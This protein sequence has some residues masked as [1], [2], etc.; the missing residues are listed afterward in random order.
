MSNNPTEQALTK[1]YQGRTF[2]VVDKDVTGLDKGNVYTTKAC[3]GRGIDSDG[4]KAPAFS[5]EEDCIIILLPWLEDN[6]VMTEL[7]V[8]KAGS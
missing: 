8:S 4:S 5:V 2:M 6:L 3:T 7:L 1:T